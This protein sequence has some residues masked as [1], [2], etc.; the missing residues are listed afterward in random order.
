MQITSDQ[1]IEMGLNPENYE[2]FMALIKTFAK[3]F[4]HS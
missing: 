3:K 1:A 4:G 2:M